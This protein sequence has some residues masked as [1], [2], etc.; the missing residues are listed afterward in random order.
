MPEDMSFAPRHE[1][2]ECDELLLICRAFVELGVEKIRLTGG[3]PMVHPD[4]PGLLQKLN[5]L[6]G[7]S[8]IA[9]TT[10]GSLLQQHIPIL[11]DSKVKQ[12]NI[13]LDSVNPETFSR[14]TRTRAGELDKVIAGIDAAVEAGIERVRLNA[15]VSNGYNHD[16]LV[17]L[18]RFAIDRQVHVAFIEEMPMGDMPDYK[19]SEKYLSNQT[20]KNQLADVFTLLPMTE[21]RQQAGPAVYHKV[22]GTQT[23]V[24]FI[25][26]H[27]QNFCSSCNR[28][29]VTRK[30]QLVLCLGND[31][32]LDLRQVIRQHAD[33]ND[34]REPL[35]A[36]KQAIADALTRKP[37]AHQFDIAQ[38]DWQVVRFMNVTGG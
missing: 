37:E 2:L 12:L 4:F 34:R 14:I 27:S 28:V 22:A 29:R 15:V 36:L 10:N 33:T 13:S 38:D 32:G 20:V 31:D 35:I 18:V 30:G 3:E 6:D 5:A 1:N 9:V 16:E 21:K 26:P 24:G 7:L 11:A 8:S 25:S 19:R 23:E 17:D